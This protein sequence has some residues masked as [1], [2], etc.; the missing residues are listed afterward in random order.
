MGGAY[1][2]PSGDGRA[3]K[4]AAVEICDAMFQLRYGEISVYE[5]FAAWSPWFDGVAWDMTEVI[6]D[7]RLRRLWV[8]LLTDGD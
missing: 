2:R 5:S 4:L 7:R 6:F 3:A 1:A 8:F